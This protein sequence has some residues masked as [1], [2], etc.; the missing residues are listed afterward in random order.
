[1]PKNKSIINLADLLKARSCS[2]GTTRIC[3]L[4]RR[5]RS[6]TAPRALWRWLDDAVAQYGDQP[7]H[8]TH[9][10]W[11]HA[12]ET[13]IHIHPRTLTLLGEFDKDLVLWSWL[14]LEPENRE[15]FW[16]EHPALLHRAM[17][18]QIQKLE[19]DRKN[20][21]TDS[22]TVPDDEWSPE[23]IER[24][25]REAALKSYGPGLN[26]CPSALAFDDDE[27]KQVRWT[28][29]NILAEQEELMEE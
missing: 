6:I 12:E 8:A 16:E 2:V 9:P 13:W 15:I 17:R 3:K 29:F 14:T 1:M 20:R 18:G 5:H 24:R 22:M 28:I 4:L 7:P 23:A 21:V 26:A 25:A 27:R 19:R 10:V 11:E